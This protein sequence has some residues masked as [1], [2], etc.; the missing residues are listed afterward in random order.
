M[1]KLHWQ[2]AFNIVIIIRKPFVPPESHIIWGYFRAVCCECFQLL[3]GDYYKVSDAAGCLIFFAFSSSWSRVKSRPRQLSKIERE[4]VDS[5]FL[6]SLT[7]CCI[8]WICFS[9]AAAVVFHFQPK[10][11]SA[12]CSWVNWHCPEPRSKSLGNCEPSG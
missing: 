8:I 6:L 11:W 3:V 10:K 9:T 4:N 12:A 5:A 2:T 1:G 7:V